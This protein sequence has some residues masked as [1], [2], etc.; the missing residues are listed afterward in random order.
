MWYRLRVLPDNPQI[1]TLSNVL[2]NPPAYST[3]LFRQPISINLTAAISADYKTGWL[4]KWYDEFRLGVRIGYQLPINGNNR[5][6]YDDS[7]VN[8]LTPFRSNMLFAQYSLTFIRRSQ[9]R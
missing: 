9:K 7:P 6:Y 5:W 1:I 8:E 4:K 2:T 3:I